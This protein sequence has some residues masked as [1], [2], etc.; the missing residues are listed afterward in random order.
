MALKKTITLTNNFGLSN[1]F[2]D[3]YIK[4]KSVSGTKEFVTAYVDYKKDEKV[5]VQKGFQFA[6][7]MNGA[8]FIK[9]AYE[10]LKTLEEFDGAIDC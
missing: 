7:D 4:V 10:H 9:Q 8:N 6:P 1:T 3:A 2:N 5:L